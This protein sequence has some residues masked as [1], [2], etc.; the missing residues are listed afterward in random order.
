[1]LEM[2]GLRKRF[3]ARP[4]LFDLSLDVERGEI[5]GLLG[6]NGAGKSTALGIL[7]GLI[8]P[9]AGTARIAGSCVV[10]ERAK[11]LEHVGAIFETPSFYEYLTGRQNLRFF[12]SLS[13]KKPDPKRLDEVIEL[14]SLRERIDEPVQNY[15]HGMRQRLA[16]AGAL[17][18]NPEFLILD[19]PTDGLDPLGIQ[20][21]RNLVRRLR[22]EYGMTVLLSSHLLS[23]V[24]Q[25]CDRVA[26]LHGGNLVF[27]GRWEEGPA[28]WRILVEPEPLAAEILSGRGWILKEGFVDLRPGEDIADLVEALAAGGIRI[29]TVEPVRRT[30]EDFYFET[31]KAA[32]DSSTAHSP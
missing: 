22:S 4:A 12:V 11:A 5:F 17:L 25:L 7:L 18:P 27:S 26:I 24:E 9:N 15:S 32:K 29:R 16:L 30:L 31:C 19:E 3:G 10:S 21:M 13:G 8:K 14:V 1:M 2:H 28:R 20:E 6:H 23:E